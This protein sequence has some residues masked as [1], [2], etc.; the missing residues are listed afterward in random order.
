LIH[1]YGVIKHEITWDIVTTKLPVLRAQVRE[2]LG[3]QP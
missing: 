2:L 1:G 3:E